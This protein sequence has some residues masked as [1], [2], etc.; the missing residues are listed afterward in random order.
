LYQEG[1]EA[2]VF[3]IDLGVEKKVE[4]KKEL[5]LTDQNQ[6]KNKELWSSD[7]EF[8]NRRI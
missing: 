3:D 6:K 1:D 4:L 8:N 5:K 7:Q 2:E